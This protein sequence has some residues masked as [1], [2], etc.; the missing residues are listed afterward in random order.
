[1]KKEST[2]VPVK[3]AGS[4]PL[5]PRQR[6]VWDLRYSQTPPLTHVVIGERLGITARTSRVLLAAA[7]KHL[8]G[9]GEPPPARTSDTGKDQPAPVES[10]EMLRGLVEKMERELREMVAE[11]TTLD[12]KMAA[13]R[14]AIEAVS[15]TIE[16]VT[17][18]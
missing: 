13:H 17:S 1:M 18:L 7:K 9:R 5:T 8:R 3:G 11:R 12:A 15:K 4:D 2:Q 6:E 14:E 10:T 16:V